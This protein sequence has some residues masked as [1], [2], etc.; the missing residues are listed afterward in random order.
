VRGERL[1]SRGVGEKAGQ[2]DGRGDESFGRACHQWS[3]R[4]DDDPGAA[5]AALTE[6]FTVPAGM[7]RWVMSIAIGCVVGEPGEADANSVPLSIEVMVPA[8]STWFVDDVMVAVPL[9]TIRPPPL[10]V[11]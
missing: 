2:P 11:P 3:P 6:P 5:F 9:R 4:L 7:S 1:V 10:L 8:N